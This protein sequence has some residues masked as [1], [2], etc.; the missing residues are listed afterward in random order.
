MSSSYDIV[1]VGAGMIG[2]SVA[3]Y[4]SK[5]STLRV[6]LIG[7]KES[8]QDW[9]HG[10]WF[11]QGRISKIYENSPYWLDLALKSIQRY[12]DIEMS[13]GIEFFTE[14]GY[15]YVTTQSAQNPKYPMRTAQNVHMSG[16]FCE[17]VTPAMLSDQFPYLSLPN[18]Q[19]S[20]YQPEMSGYVNP[21]KLVAAQQKIA[22]DLGCQIIHEVVDSI[23]ELDGKFEIRTKSENVL[24]A[25]KV[26]LANGAYANFLPQIKVQNWDNATKQLDL[27][28]RTQTVAYLEV[29]EADAE[30][31]LSNM[32]N[33]TTSYQDGLLDGAYILPPMKMPDGTICTKLGHGDFFEHDVQ[34]LTELEGWYNTHPEGDL[35]GVAELE[36]FMRKLFPSISFRNVHGG[37]CVTSNTPGK[38]APFVDCPSPG[39]YVAVGGSGHAAKSCDEIG[40][41]AANFVAFDTWTT[42]IPQALMKVSWKV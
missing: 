19:V 4:L 34:N 9:C 13:S 22:T 16:N 29:T 41:I 30:T 37:A 3:K 5:E 17:D 18:D 31:T 1:V 39:F 27:T 11:D 38:I 26:V 36:R 2:S 25:A 42:N 12:K 32:P 6:G 24:T 28:L 15:M 10:A 14:S 33:M 35:D 21:R 23:T 40:R 8:E 20:Y 7:P